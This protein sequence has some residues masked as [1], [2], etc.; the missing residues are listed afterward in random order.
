MQTATYLS[1]GGLL[2]VGGAV[3][4]FLAAIRVALEPR[5]LSTGFVLLAAVTLLGVGGAS[6]VVGLGPDAPSSFGL[7]VVFTAP[8]AVA[9]I[10]LLVNGI[11]LLSRE[12]FAA[13]TALPVVL[14]AGLIGAVAAVVT[15]ASGP[16][17][18]SWAIAST[19][20]VA[21]VAVYF[22]AHLIAFGGYALIYGSLAARPE[23]DAVVIL[24]CGLN[25]RSVTPLLAARLDRGID[26]YR[27]ALRSG[28]RP[29]LVTCGGQGPDEA[30]TEADA[31]ARYLTARGVSAHAI[32]RERHSRNTA[33]NLRNC[34]RELNRRGIDPEQLR[35]T[36]V[37]SNFH[38]LRTAGLTRR[39]GIDAQV[40]GSRTAAYF[41]P[42]AFLREFVAVLATH[43]RRSHITVAVSLLVVLLA[44][45]A[46]P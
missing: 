22:V 36:V 7:V 38:V 44:V 41:L 3:L 2:V 40:L 9:G 45:M 8:F 33:E 27:T 4:A 5:R 18:P 17:M 26:A 25:R 15:V 13:T 10:A 31:M 37:T 24:G 46:L 23:A 29:V 1:I 39:L 42:A 11:E 43:Y 34:L 21:A 12:G 16:T 6:A 19:V 35:I 28:R 30:T 32:V 14:G 20:L